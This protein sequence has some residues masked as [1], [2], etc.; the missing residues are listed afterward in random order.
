VA[1]LV[2]ATRL[3]AYVYSKLTRTEA[4]LDPSADI[5]FAEFHARAMSVIDKAHAIS[6]A[7]RSS[8][9]RQSTVKTIRLEPYDGV[10]G[11]CAQAM[12][13]ILHLIS[14]DVTHVAIFPLPLHTLWG[15]GFPP[16]GLDHTRFF[17]LLNQDQTKFRIIHL[18][19][20]FPTSAHAQFVE[21]WLARQHSVESLELCA[22]NC[23]RPVHIPQIPHV[24]RNLERLTM[25]DLDDVVN[26]VTVETLANVL[27][28][29]PG[30]GSFCRALATRSGICLTQ[31]LCI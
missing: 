7:L 27:A 6:R 15:A 5:P 2:S 8:P 20:A 29:A 28:L 3:S 13:D 18:K 14:K 17:T 9:M 12:I 16:A 25:T 19:Y 30:L 4:D 11:A 24:F 22:A 26:D 31:L 10:D 21:H 1:G 23:S